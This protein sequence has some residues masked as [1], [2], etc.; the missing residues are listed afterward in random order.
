M[1]KMAAKVFVDSNI[2]LYIAFDQ[3]DGNNR[4]ADPEKWEK[5]HEESVQKLTL[6]INDGTEMWING[7][8]IREFWKIATQI[9]AHG[10]QQSIRW[11]SERI[12]RFRKI[13]R[14][15]DENKAVRDQLL[16]LLEW[17]S[18]RGRQTHDTNIV[19]TMLAHGINTLCTGNLKDFKRYQ[20]ES[21]IDIVDP[22]AALA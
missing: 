12:E 5:Y 13:M 22:I 8:V 2:L 10:K 19:A 7:Q 17:H 1:A 18:I 20:E 4:G 21:K 16:E 9:R 15:A 6:F 11:V 14:E 3:I